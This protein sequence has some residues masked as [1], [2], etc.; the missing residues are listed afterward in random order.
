MM[1]RRSI[2]ALALVVLVA[3][4]TTAQQPADLDALVA[5][6]HQSGCRE[7]LE[8]LVSLA[9]GDD[10]DAQRASYLAGWCLARVGRHQEATEAY[11]AAAG[12]PSL[13]MH[14]RLEEGLAVLQAGNAGNAAAIFRDVASRTSAS[15]R[16]RA[17]VALG[18]AELARRNPAGATEALTTA[19]SLR[20]SDPK[21]WLLL[22]EAATAA[23]LRSVA[24]RA[25]ALAAWAFPGDPT[26]GPARQAFA[27]LRGRT[28]SA[29]QVAAEVRMRRGRR[30]VRR[31]EL[32]L[33]AAEFLAVVAARPSGRLA[34]EAWS[35][36]AEIWMNTDPR[37]SLAAFK[38]AAGLGWSPATAYYWIASIARRLGLEAEERGAN[39]ALM[40]IGPSSFWAARAWLEAGLRAEKAGR[41][42]AAGAF[43]RRSIAANP[44]SHDAAEARWR[45]GWLALREGRRGDAE[46]L[47]REAAKAAPSRGEAARAWYWVS[48]T[49]EARG[50]SD[51][52]AVL[53]MVVQE[54]PLTFYGQRARM[55]L[56][57][58]APTLA[59]PPPRAVPREVAGPA[60]EE[61]ARL[62][63]D[64]D[65]V[66]SAEDA[67][68]SRRERDLSLVR[69]L[70]EAYGR[71]GAHRQSVAYAEEAL[72]NG[73]RD[74]AMW[75]LGY[76][77]AY[78]PEVAA[79]AAAANIDPLLL[80][81]LVREESR[82]DPNAI[83]PA[84]AVG[85]A[86]LLPTTA[87]AMTGDRSFNTQRLTDPATNLRLGAQYVRLQ[88]DRFGGDVPL[89]LAAYNAGPGAARKWAGSDPDPDYFIEKIGFS[90]TRA[91]VRRV[92]GSYG[93]YRLLW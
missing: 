15:V 39:E 22:G 51:A 9:S 4:G 42:R 87:Q 56:S 13:R 26:E 88:L 60:Y 62:G 29:T 41:N 90:E 23:G 28:F 44:G 47:Y 75:R 49:M 59:P 12:H 17:F 69:F 30:L 66:E 20:S 16:G 81:A 2:L 5:Q 34:A 3:P 67:L 14:S 71:L 48:K 38:R 93:I 63:L 86:Q 31:G 8:A 65:A 45:L 91:Y 46:A 92:L 85:L 6:V 82:Y 35:R 55:R 7:G 33:A 32:E 64:A 18:Q 61:L 54:Y 89:A 1:T 84:R 53:R 80:L 43:Y 73:L 58:P 78:L 10:L 57:A 76:P 70:A 27:R 68:D 21:A 11:R 50:A 74:E 79:A 83:S 77:K 52:D 19:V 37:A 25:F 40:R 24:H 36:L 72:A